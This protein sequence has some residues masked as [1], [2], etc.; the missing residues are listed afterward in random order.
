M[1]SKRSKL[2]YTVLRTAEW[3][4]SEKGSVTVIVTVGRDEYVPLHEVGDNYQD[5]V[6]VRQHLL[7]VGLALFD[8]RHGT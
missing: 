3:G 1:L 8:V 6:A 4:G 7:N 2:C 5:R